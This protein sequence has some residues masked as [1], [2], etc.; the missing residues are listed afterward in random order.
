[1]ELP[2]NEDVTTPGGP[3][4]LGSGS[5]CYPK[6]SA[7]CHKDLCIRDDIRDPR[8]SHK[9]LRLWERGKQ[10]ETLLRSGEEGPTSGDKASP[11]GPRQPGEG[12]SRDGEE[13]HFR[14]QAAWHSLEGAL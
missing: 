8:P 5:P 3:A 9:G 7:L 14:G 4:L 10:G 12:R 13:T 6:E 11:R 2:S 1:M